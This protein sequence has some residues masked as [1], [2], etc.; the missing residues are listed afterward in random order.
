MALKIRLR[1]MGRRN[2]PTY[3][4]VVAESSMPRDG[5]IVENI[6]HYNPRT[7]PMTLAVD[8]SRALHWIG[9]GAVPTETVKSLLKK[10]GVFKPEEES[11]VERAAHAVSDTAKKAAKAA[12]TA[13]SKAAEAAEDAAEKV[14]SRGKKEEA[15]EEA[16]AAEAKAEEPKAEE[17][18]AEAEEAPA[19]EAEAEA[20]AEEKPAKKA[21]AEAD[22]E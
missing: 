22:A 10:A 5:R 14:R 13:A 8:R 2:A 16:P 20:E 4:I 7:E 17:P 21:K 15:K 9:S 12:K 1:R 3:R 11:V 19:A 18:K 6:G